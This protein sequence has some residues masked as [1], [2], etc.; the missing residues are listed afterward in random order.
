MYSRKLTGGD[1]F[2]PDKGLI[3]NQKDLKAFNK[4]FGEVKDG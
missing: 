4:L 2:K 3:K 1:K